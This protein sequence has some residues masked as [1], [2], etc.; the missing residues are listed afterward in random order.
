MKTQRPLINKQY[1]TEENHVRSLLFQQQMS[2][3][4]QSW[5]VHSILVQWYTQA[6]LP[7]DHCPDAI[8][9]STRLHQATWRKLTNAANPYLSDP[10]R[11]APLHDR[12]FPATNYIRNIQDLEFTPLPDLAHDY[13]GHMPLMFHPRAS[14]L[15]WI[16]ADMY[17]HTTDYE[18]KDLYNLARYVI[19]YSVIQEDWIPKIFW[20]WLL[21]SP[22]DFDRFVSH[23]FEL[24]PA[25][26][27]IIC[28]TDRS[29]HK[30]HTSL[31]VFDDFEHMWD[32]VISYKENM[33]HFQSSL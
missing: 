12:H 15:Q 26:L 32:M 30:P 4:Q 25:N 28:N 8:Q 29:P 17:Q 14:E 18:K 5:V 9:I 22:W 27:N 10:D 21:S 24:I 2:K 6:Q 33:K 1:T 20:A 31:F 7:A 16:L 19:E 11:Y 13:F 3:V 23:Q